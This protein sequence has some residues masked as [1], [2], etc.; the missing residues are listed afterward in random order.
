MREKDRL[1]AWES[2]NF[3][4]P[5]M[6]GSKLIGGNPWPLWLMASG[7]QNLGMEDVDALICGIS[8]LCYVI[9]S[10]LIFLYGHL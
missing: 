9:T 2:R 5:F 3:L 7:N 10:L 4:L 6:I 8:I 1:R